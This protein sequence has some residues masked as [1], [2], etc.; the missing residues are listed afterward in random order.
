MDDKNLKVVG[1]FDLTAFIITGIFLLIGLIPKITYDLRWPILT[2]D[3]ILLT[4]II[5]LFA[6]SIAN[7][8][9][10]KNIKNFIR[11]GQNKY[12]EKLKEESKKLI[13]TQVKSEVYSK[14][15]SIAKEKE[16]FERIKNVKKYFGLSFSLTSLSVLLVILI[17][18]SFFE[19]FS[20][21]NLFFIS[22][23]TSLYPI[24]QLILAFWL[25]Y[26]DTYE[27]KK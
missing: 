15:T 20:N 1:W 2:V 14:L 11:Q 16:L 19:N 10:Y 21:N 9:V 13:K 23:W 12:E 5:T 4:I 7:N 6:T 25:A 26:T 8:N 24:T 27:V 18:D 3:G 22:F 17:P